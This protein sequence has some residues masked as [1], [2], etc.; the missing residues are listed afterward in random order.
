MPSFFSGRQWGTVFRHTAHLEIASPP[1]T[2]PSALLAHPACMG[3]LD[4]REAVGAG[5]RG[6]IV[7]GR[8]LATRGPG[9]VETIG[10]H[11]KEQACRWRRYFTNVETV[12]FFRGRVVTLHQRPKSI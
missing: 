12:N 5:H 11:P 8:R 1:A 9:P 2:R 10:I 3:D 7:L 6:H 4:L